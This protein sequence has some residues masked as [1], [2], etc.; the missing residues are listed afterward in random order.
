MTARGTGSFRLPEG[1]AV[2]RGRPLSFTFNGRALSGFEGDSLA[3]ALLAN[4]IRVVGRSFKYHRPRG[5][6]TAGEE[7]PCA[8]VET[9]E[10]DARIPT[11][12]APMVPLTEGLVVNSQNCW[13]SAG[14]G[15]ITGLWSQH[16]HS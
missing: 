5:V 12:R 4:G 2:D 11:C 9:G 3:S 13:P 7:E 6:Y 8:L 14:G 16:P 1:G 15:K 10:G